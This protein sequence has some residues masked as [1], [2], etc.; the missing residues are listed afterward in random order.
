VQRACSDFWVSRLR[1]IAESKL[2]QKGW[3]VSNAYRFDPLPGGR[4]ARNPIP[5]SLGGPRFRGECE[6]CTRLW[7][8][9]PARLTETDMDITNIQDARAFKRMG[10]PLNT[11]TETRTFSGAYSKQRFGLM[12]VNSVVPLPTTSMIHLRQGGGNSA[13]ASTE[14]LARWSAPMLPSTSS[15][16]R[17]RRP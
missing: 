8:A 3:L 15:R 2:R 12:K 17:T 11:P 14:Y 6:P 10:I 7:P 1:H 16:T 9:R 4:E 13:R 5:P